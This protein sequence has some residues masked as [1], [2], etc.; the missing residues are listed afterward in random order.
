MV[1]KAVLFDFDGTIA[2][3]HDAFLEIVNDLAD[4]FGYPQVDQVQLERL[5]DLSSMDIIRYSE[6]PSLKIPFIIKRVK[7]ELSKKISTLKPYYAIDKALLALHENDYLI[8]IVT[9]NLKE[10][11][12]TFLKNNDLDTLFSFIHSGTTLFGKNKMINA[13]LKEHK[14]GCD[15]VIYVGDE[16]RDIHAAQKSNILMISVGWGF[17]SPTILAKHKPDFLVYH[18]IELV[19]IIEELS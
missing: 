15:E 10:N 2:D 5:K 14:L 18:P 9:S 6:I 13:V 7:K 3:T 12:I 1:I 11:V 19:K 17:N 8:G 16:T 4:E